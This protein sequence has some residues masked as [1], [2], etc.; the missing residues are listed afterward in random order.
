MRRLSIG[1][2]CAVLFL[3]LFLSG[4]GGSGGSTNPSSQQATTGGVNTVI[5]DDASQ[6]WAT[7]GVKVMS[8]SLTPQGG[9][10][11]VSI[12][13]APS[14]GAPY[15]NLVQ[16][17][18][19]G[20]II[21]NAQIAP[22]TYASATITVS[23]NPTDIQLIAAPNP[24]PGFPLTTS[25]PVPS[26]QIQVMNAQ[27]STG[28]LTVPLTIALSPTVTVTAGASS[29]L[30]L[31]FDLA[32]PAFIVDHIV[33][34]GTTI[35]T[36][37]FNPAVRHHPLRDITKLVLRHLYGTVSSV[38][39]DNTSITVSKVFPAVPFTNPETFAT[40][41]QSF[42][43]LADSTNGTIFRDLDAQTVNTITNFSSVAGTLPTKYVRVAARYQQ[44]GTLVATRIWA[45]TTFSK[46]FVSPEGHVLDVNR[47]AD[48]FT[49]VNEDGSTSVIQVNS[50]TQFWF[51]QAKI[52]TGTNFLALG[53][54][55]FV[56]GFK[57]HVGPVDP[58]ANPLVADT[59]DIEIARFGGSI[60]GANTTGFTYNR[61]FAA[62]PATTTDD[63]T[64]TLDYISP[65][66]ANGENS[67][68]TAINGY[69]WWY[70]AQPTGTLDFGSTAVQDFVNAV[71]G[72]VSYGTT[73][74]P[75]NTAFGVLGTQTVAGESY[76]TW[77]DPANPNNAW[78][79]QWAVL[80][81]TPAP[82]ATVSTAAGGTT[83]F[84]TPVAAPSA[85]C[86]AVQVNLSNTPGQATLVYNVNRSGAGVITVT[87]M[88]IT[89]ASVL[90][91]VDGALVAS[92]P[93][94]VKV[95]GVPGNSALNAYVLF[96]FTGTTPSQ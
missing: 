60:S 2:I 71:G 93:T 4:C 64:T 53:T 57:V 9:G 39:T 87:P 74:T 84:M 19:L 23:A 28:S 65:N 44:N 77:N 5:S 92:P 26:A 88:D 13:T 35:W 20:E 72:S 56:R 32:N 95:Y 12:Y 58:T 15:I 46:V 25:T 78:S 82:L 3:A 90:T 80:L 63:Y 17:D 52:A 34:G 18:Q 75:V 89:Q 73:C 86:N 76:A 38:S 70:F 10:T 37:N 6:D 49:I 40:S 94:Y 24:E 85:S 16:L 67:S 91:Q 14:S 61:K 83:F 7:I 1:F 29:P 11:P 48:T 79:A 55:N 41:T 8:V 66:T 47:S 59:V 50:S 27:G 96:Y 30:D 69:K 36:V 81:P 43:I 45:S 22:G 21:G 54:T 33:N 68:A 42:T 31:E 62:P 51:D